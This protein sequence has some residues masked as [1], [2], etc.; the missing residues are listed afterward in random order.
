LQ[1]GILELKKGEWIHPHF[2]LPRERVV[3]KTHKAVYVVSGSMKFYFYKK[4]VKVKEVIVYEG[5]I[6]FLLE[7]GFGFKAI[8]DGTRIIEVK[9]GPY[10]GLEGDKEKFFPEDFHENE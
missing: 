5:E 6:V 4:G 10:P 8:E 3:N 9:Q 2:H 1:I 7:G